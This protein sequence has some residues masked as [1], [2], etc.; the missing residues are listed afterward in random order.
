MP[1]IKPSSDLR[2][3]YN[4]ILEL[5]RKTNEPIYL[6]KNGKGDAVLLSMEAYEELLK[7]QLMNLLQPAIDDAVAG[8]SRP[9]DE[10]FAEW[11]EELGHEK[12]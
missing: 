5:S 10:F 6:T 9:A 8:R 12:I 11:M 2:N 7:D 4:E 1:I 3:N